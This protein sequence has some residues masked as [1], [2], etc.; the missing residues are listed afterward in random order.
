MLLRRLSRTLYGKPLY[1]ELNT[2][3]QKN[4]AGIA[5]PTVS[6]VS[7]AEIAVSVSRFTFVAGEPAPV[8]FFS[9]AR[10]E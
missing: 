2:D 1:L 8:L 5:V 9:I 7:V 4:T 10:K 6:F 3:T